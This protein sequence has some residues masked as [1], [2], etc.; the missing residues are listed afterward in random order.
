MNDL[1]GVNSNKNGL[2]YQRCYI[3][4]T[5]NFQPKKHHLKKSKG[6]KKYKRLIKEW[7]DMADYAK[8]W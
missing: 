5:K 2:L 6:D 1:K 4:I 7:S 8:H 3:N